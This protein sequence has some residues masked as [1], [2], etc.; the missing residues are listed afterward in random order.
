MAVVCSEAASQ[1]LRAQVKCL[2]FLS[3][4]LIFFWLFFSSGLSQL[5]P[6]FPLQVWVLKVSIHCEGCKRKVKK[7]L[8]SIDGVYTTI[9]DSDQQKV[10][11]TGNVSLETLT[12]RLAKAGKHAEIWP[13]KLGGKEKQL[14]KTLETNK[15]N[16]QE[17]ARSPGTNKASAK[18][19]G[20]KVTP[21][22]NKRKEQNE[23][24]KNIESSS[25]RPSAG[26]S[27][28]KEN[29]IGHEGCSP[30]KGGAGKS[31]EK[32][33]TKGQPGISDKSG[34]NHQNGHGTLN[35][36]PDVG[37]KKANPLTQQIYTGPKGCFVP[38]PTLGLNYNAPHLGK[39]PEFLYSV[40]PIPFSYSNDQTEN[41]EDQAK[42]Q[43]YLDYFSEEN[44]HGCF[45]M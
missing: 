16:S 17:N 30:D 35:V 43:A 45:I 41:Y 4:F 31:G 37:H 28:S 20:F 3:K 11:V 32:K 12:K 24:S 39:G 2:L 8:Q 26:S 6:F 40:P 1:R 38:P 7:V 44:A 33:E 22:E 27:D 29:A 9:I 36:D 42:S 34:S 13:E 14:I 15:G 19:V 21:V 23:K 18:K 10:T 5:I 25:R